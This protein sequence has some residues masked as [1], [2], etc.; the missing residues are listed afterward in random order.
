MASR[1]FEVNWQ[2]EHPDWRPGDRPP[3]DASIDA[4]VL[5]DEETAIVIT[6]PERRSVRPDRGCPPE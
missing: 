3:P 5:L 6:T 4:V 2:H 1:G